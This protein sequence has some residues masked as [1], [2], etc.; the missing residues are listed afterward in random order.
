MNLPAQNYITLWEKIWFELSRVLS[1]FRRRIAPALRQRRESTWKG[2][3]GGCESRCSDLWLGRLSTERRPSRGERYLWLRL[4]RFESHQQDDDVHHMSDL[5]VHCAY[6]DVH[7]RWVKRYGD[8][9]R[10]INERFRLISVA[11]IGKGLW[12]VIGHVWII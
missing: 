2:R 4:S 5:F 11:R 7:L 9:V 6:F 10:E 8:A 12:P 3:R 1:A